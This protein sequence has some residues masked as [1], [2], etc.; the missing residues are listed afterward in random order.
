LQHLAGS[1][2]IADRVRFL[3]WQDD[4]LS[5][6]QLVDLLVVPSRREPLDNVIVEAWMAGYPVFATTADGPLAY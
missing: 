2:G 6:M 4:P 3:G 5:P 1:L